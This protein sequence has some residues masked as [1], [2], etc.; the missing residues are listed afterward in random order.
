MK[1]LN[2]VVRIVSILLFANGSLSNALA[3]NPSTASGET[4]TLTSLLSMLEEALPTQTSSD[5][6]LL[7]LDEISD[8]RTTMDQ[9]EA[10]ELFEYLR[11]RRSIPFQYLDDGCY[12]RAHKMSRLL[13]RMGYYS[14]KVFIEGPRLRASRPDGSTVAWNYHVAPVVFVRAPR[15]GLLQAMVLDP[16]VADGPLSQKAWV[17]LIAGNSPCRAGSP[18]DPGCR[19]YRT[20]RY[21]YWPPTTLDDPAQQWRAG[22]IFNANLTNLQFRFAAAAKP[23]RYSERGAAVDPR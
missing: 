3:E 17:A 22:H 11:E 8:K 1:S 15:S 5:R 4:D 20:P 23:H 9:A 12:A 16:S 19:Y 6:T 14:E 2:R 21:T 7:E 18:N 10:A 13:S